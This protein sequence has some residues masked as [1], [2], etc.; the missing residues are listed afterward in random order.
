MPHSLSPK[1]VESVLKLN[2]NERFS[3]TIKEIVKH[4]KIWILTDEHGCVMLNTED[5]ECVPIWPNQ[6]FASLW[7][8]GEWDSCKAEPI[9]TA[10][11]FSRWTQ[12]LEEDGLSVVVFPN[13]DEEGVV[14]FPDELEFELK[15]ADKKR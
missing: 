11:W 1:E 12:G 9:S 8:T 10:K 2:E 15:K 14:V 3:Y 5:E 13:H 4:K 6:E 7:A